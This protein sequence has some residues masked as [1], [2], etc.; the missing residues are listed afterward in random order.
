MKLYEIASQPVSK[1]D[2]DNKVYIVYDENGKEYSKYPFQHVWD[3]SPARDAAQKDVV[4]LKN[5]LYKERQEKMLATA[6]A[7]PLSNLE[8]EYIDL[9]NKVKKY[10]LILYPKD[11]SKSILDD[12]TKELYVASI[13][14]WQDRLQKIA[15]AGV[16]RQ[17]VLMGTYK[18]LV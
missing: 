11:K 9:D 1:L 7:K 17:S 4:K 8:K 15:D 6:E 14:K 12:E 13:D 2:I 10:F 16:I 5:T 18:S 3:S